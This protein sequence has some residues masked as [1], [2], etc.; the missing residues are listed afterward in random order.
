MDARYH[1]PG[2]IPK[3]YDF[4][5]NTHSSN[6]SN[7]PHNI[8]PTT[9]SAGR[10][11]HQAPLIFPRLQ[12]QQVLNSPA[13]LSSSHLG[14]IHHERPRFL[15]A[16]NLAPRPVVYN[17][18]QSIATNAP[19]STAVPQRNDKGSSILNSCVFL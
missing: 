15:S 11:F 3:H 17:S 16:W 13:R 7:P 18:I 19:L 5:P 1:S 6:N 14:P 8:R 12:Q 2:N 9:P 4:I 10:Y